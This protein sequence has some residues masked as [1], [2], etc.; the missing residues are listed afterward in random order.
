VLRR[1]VRYPGKRGERGGVV[2][3][4]YVVQNV[5]ILFYILLIAAASGGTIPSCHTT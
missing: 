5:V 3:K 1:S 4:I 2:L